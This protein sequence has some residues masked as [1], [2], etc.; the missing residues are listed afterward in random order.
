MTTKDGKDNVDLFRASI[1]CM[2]L[3]WNTLITA[4]MWL[5]M[6]FGI[7]HELGDAVP[8]WLWVLYFAY[9]PC[10]MFGVLVNVAFEASRKVK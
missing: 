8:Q 7:L 2:V 10:Y 4:P 5:A 9:A 3:A 1:G 6:L